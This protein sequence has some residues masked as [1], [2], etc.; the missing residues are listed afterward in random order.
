MVFHI[1]STETTTSIQTIH[2][3]DKVARVIVV[4]VAI[5]K[6]E[7]NLSV[8]GVSRAVVNQNNYLKVKIL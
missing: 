7:V 1:P 5:E 3:F 2:N 6:V 4:I 8:L